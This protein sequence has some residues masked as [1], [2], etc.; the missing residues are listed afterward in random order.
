ME[1]RCSKL[2]RYMVCAG[3]MHLQVDEP[4]AGDPAKE[5]TACGEYLQHLLENRPIPMQASNGWY[6]DDDMKFYSTAIAEDI[7]AR[8]TTGVLCEK[9]IDWQTRSGIWIRGQYDASY[10]DNQGRLCIDDLKYGWGIVEVKENWQTLGYA[11]GEVIRRGQ[12][13]E[14][15][16]IRIL[17]PRPHHEDGYYREW[18]LTYSQLLEYKERIEARC[19]ELAN[20]RSDFQTSDKC[21]YCKGAAEAC[22]AFSRLYYRALEIS[23]EFVQDSLSNEEVAQQLD[24]IKRASEVLKIKLDSLEQLGADRIKKGQIIPGY[25]QSN[26]YSQREWKQGVTAASLF[27]FTGKVV[28]EKSLMSPAKA[29]KLGISKKLV[30]QLSSSRLTGV[31]LEKKNGSDVGNKIFGNSNPV[32]GN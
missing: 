7:F 20:G 25:I 18:V 3:Y 16:V 19:M 1:I 10:V 22:P 32:G 28:E 13:F 8:T 2:A 14:Y 6:F 27:A 31:K 5:G 15:I 12:A 29:E 26:R 21:K 30:E 9:R 17:Q 11:I 4:E 24:Q 23:T